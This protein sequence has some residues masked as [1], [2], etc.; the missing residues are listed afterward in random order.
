KGFKAKLGIET[1]P[2]ILLGEA[3]FLADSFWKAAASA[4]AGSDANLRTADD[5][6]EF[7]VAIETHK[8]AKLLVLRSAPD[9]KSLSLQDDVLLLMDTDERKR[10]TVLERN[11]DWSDR[12]RASAAKELDRIARM[13]DPVDRVFAVDKAR[14]SSAWHFY[15]RLKRACLSQQGPT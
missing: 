6:R 4:Y 7:Q 10:R 8:G 9:K 14:K 3:K 5:E 2:A 12:P 1:V 15:T 13:P 11:P